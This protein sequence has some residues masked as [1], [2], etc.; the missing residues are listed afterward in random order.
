MDCDEHAADAR[1]QGLRPNRDIHLN[2]NP[3]FCEER[4]PL[5]ERNSL[6]GHYNH[7]TL[8]VPARAKLIESEETQLLSGK[9][10]TR[11]ELDVYSVDACEPQIIR[12]P[13]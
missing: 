13:F 7:S 5:A 9:R 3:Q 4:L 12:Y 10:F 1:S 2:D 11:T 8:F 6:C